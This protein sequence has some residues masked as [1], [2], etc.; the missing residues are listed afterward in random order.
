M[1][2]KYTQSYFFTIF[3]LCLSSNVFACD[4]SDTIK[5]ANKNIET[6]TDSFLNSVNDSIDKLNKQLEVNIKENKNRSDKANVNYSKQLKILL[7]KFRIKEISDNSIEGYLL[8]VKLS[9]TT[10]EAVKLNQFLFEYKKLI[11]IESKK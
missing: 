3:F 8:D 2:K 9:P 5:A 10:S 6:S 7:S 11:Q 1:I 4:C